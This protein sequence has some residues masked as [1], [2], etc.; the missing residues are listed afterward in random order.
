LVT[1]Q[2]DNAR[3]HKTAAVLSFM[4][5]NHINTFEWSPSGYES[6]V[7]AHPRGGGMKGEAYFSILPLVESFLHTSPSLLL[8]SSNLTISRG[9]VRIS[10]VI[11]EVGQ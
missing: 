5:E 7:W 1:F 10:A 9:L 11:S 3:I 2:Q 4:E 6:G 8:N